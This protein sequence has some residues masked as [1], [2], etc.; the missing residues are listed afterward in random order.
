MMKRLVTHTLYVL[1]AAFLLT[2]C[3]LRP[4]TYDYYPYCDV[5]I[6]VDWSNLDEAPTGM[7]ALF[8]P[9][10]GDSPIVHRTNSVNKTTVSL[11]EGV[12]N[13]I[14][15]NE[16]MN[17]LSGSMGFR[18]MDKYETAEIHAIESV[19]ASSWGSKGWYSKADGEIVAVYPE[20]F[21]VATIEKFT[22]TEDMVETQMKARSRSKGS[23]G[24]TKS[25]TKATEIT[26]TP[27][28]IIARG[29]IIV[30]VDSIQNMKSVRGSIQGMAE[31]YLPS[32]NGTGSG[33]VTHLL[34]DKTW[35][36]E[37]YIDDPTQGIISCG[38][39]S[40]GMPEMLLS[41]ADEKQ[42]E[43]AFLNLEVL[44]IDNN[45]ENIQRFNIYVGDK[46]DISEETGRITLNI[47]I[48]EGEDGNLPVVLPDVEPEGGG[49]FNASIND[50]GETVIISVPL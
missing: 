36:V 14:I 41:K 23:D 29:D 25:A 7:T 17:Y 27:K 28:N 37:K 34:E 32:I 39:S 42:C 8:Y 38:F 44:L 35:I 13:V 43:N 19:L 12:Y 5:D 2:S 22:V 11:R 10:N 20:P 4:L 50:W 33:E 40:F 47:E 15:F 18:G 49:G 21:A 6:Y 31:S 24:D 45:P 9:E 16:D 26:I 30:H 3:T 1:C 46:I 48:K